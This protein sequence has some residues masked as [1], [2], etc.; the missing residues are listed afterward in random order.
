MPRAHL[1]TQVPGVP[2]SVTAVAA[3]LGVSAST[4][5]TWE[6]RYGLGPGARPAGSHRRYLPEDVQRLSRMTDL[7]RSGV[8]AADAAATVLAL[9]DDVLTEPMQKPQ[10]QKARSRVLC[11]RNSKAT[12]R[13][14]SAISMISSGR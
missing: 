4:L 9:G 13:K 11:S 5:R 7:I 2:L 6:R 14:I 8:S 12:P 10:S 1:G 3:K